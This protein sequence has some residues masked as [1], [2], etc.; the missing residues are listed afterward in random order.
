MTTAELQNLYHQFNTEYFESTLPPCKLTWSRALTRAAGNIDVRRREIKLS[1]PLL[2]E[3][4]HNGTLFAPEYSICGVLCDNSQT[5]I[6]EILKHEMIHL[7]LF[8]RGLPHGHTPEFRAKAREIG[9]PKTR[10][11]ITL[12][13]PKSGWQY[14]CAACGDS[15]ARRR[16][17]GRPVACA[18]CCKTFN[19]GQYDAR[20]KLKGQ[21]LTS[22]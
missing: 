20:F 4:F 3:A 11:S 5:A 6:R 21:R 7:W 14:S 19:K 15:F 10:H 9:Q 8:E 17:Y 13:L 16:R 22:A 2:L 12:P 1:V 18:R